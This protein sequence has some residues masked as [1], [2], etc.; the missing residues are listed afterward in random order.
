MKLNKYMITLIALSVFLL[1][2]GKKTTTVTEFVKV[3]SSPVA[4]DEVARVVSEVNA[5]RF[6]QGQAP[7]VPGL[8]C[9][10][11]NNT[12]GAGVFPI[13]TSTFPTSLP[14]AVTSWVYLGDIN[15]PD[16]SASLG[17]NLLPSALRSSYTS[18]YA[19]RCSGQMVVTAADYYSYSLRSDD[20]G[21]FYV[22][23]V[24]MT[25]L[26][27]THSPTTTT[28]ARFLNRGIHSVRVD[29]MQAGG[30]QALQLDVAGG[31]FYR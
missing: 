9:S 15:Q 11:Y 6:A 13:G 30:D 25:G 31:L 23:N 12:G 19:V 26:N 14:S 29:F 16:S 8:V 7:L 2:C 20:A 18:S 27:T 17:L 21:M 4:V 5:Q 3:P 28:G 22:D 10:L 1:A 24:L